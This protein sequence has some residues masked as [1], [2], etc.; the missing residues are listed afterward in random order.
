VKEKN[1]MAYKNTVLVTGGAGFIGSAFL[2]IL[3]PKHPDWFFINLDALTYAG[4][5]KK[6]E[7]ISESPNYNFVHGNICDRILIE[8][9]FEE[10]PIN[11]VVNFAA[12]SHVDN[13]IKDASS[14]VETNIKGTYN[15]LDVS[16]TKWGY[17]GNSKSN[18]NFLF[19][20]ISTDE[21]YGSLRLGEKK[22]TEKSLISPNSPY[23]ASKA[24]ADVLVR[25]YFKTYGVPTIITRS[26][27]NYGPHQN[28]EKFFPTLLRAI[29][30]NKEIPVYGEGKNIRDWIFVEDNVM[31]IEKVMKYGVVGEIYNIGGELE[32]SN[33]ELTKK[34]ISILNS[35]TTVKFVADRLGHDFRYAVDSSKLKQLGW[36]VITEF[37]YG[38]KLT[39]D[40]YLNQVNVNN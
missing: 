7:A 12:E 14:F 40:F 4:D 27:N 13:S 23:S 36:G 24:A 21:V 8:K 20:Q 11:W 39:Y 25:S 18:S 1:L 19:L 2:R 5:L 10:Y 3:V 31:A 29:I 6:V 32:L 38:V 16:K 35:P 26:S 30:S 22:W 9:L 33:I 15:L 34:V 28:N 17:D 37:T